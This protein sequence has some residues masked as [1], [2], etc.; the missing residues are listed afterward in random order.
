MKISF[1]ITSYI[2]DVHL[3][4]KLLEAIQNQTEAPDELIVYSSDIFELKVPNAINIA[5]N[6][7]PINTIVSSKRTMQSVARNVCSFIADGDV[8]IFFD[9]DD[10]PH[11]Q[12]IEITRYIFNTYKPDFFL[13]NYSSNLNDN[14]IEKKLLEIRNDLIVNDTNTNLYCAGLSIHHS[15]IAVRKSV[16]QKVRFNES[17]DSY[18]KEDGIFCQDLV[19]AKFNG[20]FIN[21]QLVQYNQ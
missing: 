4:D 6:N 18:R 1:C 16:F 19:K 10:I 9:V 5:N 3:L 17:H 8:I 21:E 15:H 13:H 12:K 11:K 7:V 2:N 14:H 20:V